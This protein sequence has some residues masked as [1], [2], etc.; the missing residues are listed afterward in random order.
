MDE[1]VFGFFQSLILWQME[2]FNEIEPTSQLG[3]DKEQRIFTRQSISGPQFTILHP[4]PVTNIRKVDVAWELGTAFLPAG[5]EGSFMVIWLP[6][7]RRK[8][9]G[10][11]RVSRKPICRPGINFFQFPPKWGGVDRFDSP[12]LVPVRV[13]PLHQQ[14]AA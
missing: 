10:R 9:I 12:E 14:L 5:E 6:C 13:V 4:I 11:H 1:N 2:K 7:A 3:D 8:N